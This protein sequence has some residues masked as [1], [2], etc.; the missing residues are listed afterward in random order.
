MQWNLLPLI[1]ILFIDNFRHIYSVRVGHVDISIIV[2]DVQYIRNIYIFDFVAHCF[3]VAFVFVI[4]SYDILVMFSFH[5]AWWPSWLWAILQPWWRHQ[6][7]TFSAS[8]AIYA[9]HSPATAEFPHKGQSRGALM[10]SLICT[11]INGWV[12]NRGAGD[13][14]RHSVHYDVTVMRL[15]DMDTIDR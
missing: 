7:V 13:L 2:D 15:N 9:G 10:F 3:S 12:S 8:L 11:W 1:D 6:M 14:R 5:F 4:S